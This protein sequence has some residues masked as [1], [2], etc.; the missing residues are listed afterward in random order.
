MVQRLRSSPL[1]HLDSELSRTR[2]HQPPIRV[3][4]FLVAEL[5]PDECNLDLQQ[6]PIG[7]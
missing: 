1:R 3:C 7:R 2:T 5:Q 4:S 6:G